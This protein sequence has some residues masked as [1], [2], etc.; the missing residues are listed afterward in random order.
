MD[1]T[2][3][4]FRMEDVSSIQ[5][6]ANNNSIA[7]YM[8]NGFPFPFTLKDSLALI[9]LLTQASSDRV[10]AR[11]ICVD[12]RAV[13]SIGI[14]VQDDVYCKT[15]DIA[16]WLGE[17][18]WGH[19]IMTRAIRLVC[20]KAFDL[21]DIVRIQAEPFAE[22]LASQRVLEKAGFYKEGTLRSRIYKN[23]K[24]QDAYVYALIREELSRN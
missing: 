19:G 3:R 9:R 7:Q 12:D 21:F 13:G 23:G 14:F 11:A 10:L 6:Y 17:P 18:Y 8:R 2:L 16:Y 24:L 4:P 1:F 20:K 22:N 5:C 15:A